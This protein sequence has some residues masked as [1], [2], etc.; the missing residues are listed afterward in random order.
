[1]LNNKD[2]MPV[3]ILGKMQLVMGSVSNNSCNDM[4]D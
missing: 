1:M 3:W 2:E 4:V